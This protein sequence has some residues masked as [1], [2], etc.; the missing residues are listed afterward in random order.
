V[1]RQPGLRPAGVRLAPATILVELRVRNYALIQDLTL[2]FK[3]GFNVLTGETGAGKSILVGALSLL[4]GGKPDP[5]M[6]R[7]GA[8]SATIEARFTNPGCIA[9]DCE[10]LGIDRGN[11]LTLRRRVERDGRGTIH[12]NDSSLTL[13]GLGQL[14]DRLVD[15][16]GQ[17]QHQLLLRPQVHLETL[18]AY[19]GISAERE[20]FAA[21]FA[22]CRRVDEELDRL[23]HELS[24]RHQRRELTEFQYREL[25]DASIL[26]GEVE[27][28]RAEQTLLQTSE[29][30]FA[31]IRRLEELL[32]EQESSILGSLAAVEKTLAELTELDNSLASHRTSVA[33]SRALLDD[34]WRALVRYHDALDFSPERV[35]EINARLFLV[36][37]LERKYRVPAAELPDLAA[38]LQAE[39][40]SLELD[41]TRVDELKQE[42]VR[43]HEELV[44]HA[45]AL[46]RK[47]QQAR[48]KLEKAL[49]EEFAAMGLESARLEVNIASAGNSLTPSGADSVEF[50]F[51]ANPGEPLRPLRKVASGGELSRIML[52]LKGVLAG[53][54]PVPVLVFDEIDVGIGGRVA[55]NVGRRL[56]RLSS[57]HQ[58]ICITHLPQI[59]KHADAH[60]VVTKQTRAGRTS[61][62]IRELNPEQRVNELARMT[63]GA[64]ITD[65][66]LAHAREM[67][68]T[69]RPRSSDGDATPTDNRRTRR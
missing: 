48:L 56:A 7:S 53:V 46:S 32:Y 10:R 13:A 55:E 4:L 62:S 14:C 20:R 18:D 43:R 30:R 39:L 3:P 5:D 17:H 12:A 59:A 50:L 16:H 67:L 19:A 61:T 21:D 65:S 63:S 35:E 9:A 45:A 29:R 25:R 8:D 44:Q 54:D 15:I 28:L 6:I 26:P 49:T 23:Q 41:E 51:S 42:S 22:D 31:L 36:E 40:N 52:A 47:R 33:D 69:A 37:K 66:G 57:T 68:N 27:A 1:V 58:V 60:F 34:L 11:E 38:K 64:R 2:Q 24:E